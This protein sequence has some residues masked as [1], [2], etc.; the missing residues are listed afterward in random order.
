[1]A[2]RREHEGQS[3][4][5]GVKGRLCPEQGFVG[6]NADVESVTP[7]EDNPELTSGLPQSSF[8]DS[9]HCETLGDLEVVERERLKRLEAQLVTF[10]D[11]GAQRLGVCCFRCQ[12]DVMTVPRSPHPLLNPSIPL[13]VRILRSTPSAPQWARRCT[14]RGVSPGRVGGRSS[15]RAAARASAPR[16]SGAGPRWPD[17]PSVPGTGRV[18]RARAIAGWLLRGYP[19]DVRGT[20]AA[21][22]TAARRRWPSPFVPRAR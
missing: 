1:M 20:A 7:P 11:L 5:R 17:P 10:R 19:P 4:S 14:I 8:L 9:L 21:G 12:C 15:R 3:S 2:R 18:P 16:R 13:T 6:S 22:P